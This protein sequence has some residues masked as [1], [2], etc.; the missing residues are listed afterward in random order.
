MLA[1][2]CTR[3]THSSKICGW[4]SGVGDRVRTGAPSGSVGF[5][6]VFDL[7][8]CVSHL[9]FLPS[10]HLVFYLCLLERLASRT[11]ET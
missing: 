11:L 2:L 7:P 9:L 4:D 6:S 5:S 10:A 1:S 8:G 3:G